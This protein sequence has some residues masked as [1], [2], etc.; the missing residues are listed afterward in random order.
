VGNTVALRSF[1]GRGVGRR[2]LGALSTSAVVLD[3]YASGS[4]STYAGAR[5]TY[6]S[7]KA[8][9][10]SGRDGVDAVIAPTIEESY[11]QNWS[12]NAISDPTLSGLRSALDSA[13]AAGETTRAAREADFRS[14]VRTFSL[15]AGPAGIL[16]WAISE[17]F[18]WIGGLFTRGADGNTLSDKNDATAAVQFLWDRWRVAPPMFAADVS[19]AR[20]YATLVRWFVAYLDAVDDGWREQWVAVVDHTTKLIEEKKYDVLRDASLMGLFPLQIEKWA[21]ISAGLLAPH[22]GVG[23]GEPY[24]IER[25]KYG[26]AQHSTTMTLDDFKRLTDPL[27]AGIGLM[28]A[29][30]TGAKWE[31]CMEAAVAFNELHAQNTGADLTAQNSRLRAVFLDT[32][33]FALESESRF[34]IGATVDAGA[35]SLADASSGIRDFARSSIIDPRSAAATAPEEP[36]TSGPSTS[37]IVAGVV[38]TSAIGFLV[39]S[40]GAALRRR[41]FGF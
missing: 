18:L 19:T 15:L 4:S 21:P 23:W 31:P 10:E 17:A 26:N 29:A 9:Y 34:R 7:S 5:D 12:G 2:G 41:L 40:A 33:K 35:S 1:P 28:V 13:A 27:A 14:R 16:F 8:A 39:S 25:D 3:R 37:T 11:G 6:T 22:G 38:V 32:M 30:Y 20:L 36:A 24:E